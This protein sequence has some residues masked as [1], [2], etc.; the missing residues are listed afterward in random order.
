GIEQTFKFRPVRDWAWTWDLSMGYLFDSIF[1]DGAEFERQ[2][3]S[4]HAGLAMPLINPRDPTKYLILPDKE[5]LFRFNYQWLIARYE[6]ESVIDKDR[7][8]RSDYITQLSFG[9]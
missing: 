6:N 3:H 5:L 8:K 1:A 9:L 4:I 7:D 2:E